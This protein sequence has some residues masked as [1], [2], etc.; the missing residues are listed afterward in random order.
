MPSLKLPQTFKRRLFWLLVC[1]LTGFAVGWIGD[2]FTDNEVWFLALP[3]TVAIGWLFFANPT[4]C[5]SSENRHKKND[6]RSN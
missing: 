1:A 2:Y 6:T 4:E 5:L 3:I